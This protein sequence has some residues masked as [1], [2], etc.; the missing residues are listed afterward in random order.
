MRLREAERRTTALRVGFPVVADSLHLEDESREGSGPCCAPIPGSP[1]PSQRE[2]G[3]GDRAACRSEIDL[4]A[5]QDRLHVQPSGAYG[6]P[7]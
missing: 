5:Q 2:R 4:L 1:L 7:I 6:R 3:W